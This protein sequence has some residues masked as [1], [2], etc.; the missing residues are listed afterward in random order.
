MVNIQEDNNESY[1][2][3]KKDY[4]DLKLI[5]LSFIRNKKIILFITFLGIL[6][7]GIYAFSQKKV[8]KGEFQI[9]INNNSPTR[10][11]NGIDPRLIQFAGIDGVNT[12]RLDTQVGI[13]N[14][15]SVLM[16]VFD[17]VKSKKA[18][19]KDISKM[20]FKKW[21]NSNLKIHTDLGKLNLPTIKQTLYFYCYNDQHIV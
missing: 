19:N 14:S 20:R 13:L 18:I 6:I 10:Q 2:H 1:S 11:F 5:F 15:P 7:S 8:Y 9:V 21:K 4:I 3:I 17:F 12:T 16:D